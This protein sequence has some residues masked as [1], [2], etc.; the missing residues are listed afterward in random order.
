MIYMFT[1]IFENHIGKDHV[2]NISFMEWNGHMGMISGI[3][4]KDGKWKCLHVL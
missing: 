4:I 1:S 2:L 3:Q